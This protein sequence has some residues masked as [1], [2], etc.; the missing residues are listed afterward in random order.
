MLNSHLKSNRVRFLFAHT[1]TR[2]LNQFILL[3]YCIALLDNMPFF[4]LYMFVYLFTKRFLSHCN[5]CCFDRFVNMETDLNFW[6]RLYKPSN[7]NDWPNNT[8][9][10]FIHAQ[11]AASSHQL[12]LAFGMNAYFSQNSF[13]LVDPDFSLI[14]QSFI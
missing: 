2:M 13:P 9:N 1:S 3:K 5:T 12:K 7:W 14:I 11:P 10:K 4:G 6:I 8:T